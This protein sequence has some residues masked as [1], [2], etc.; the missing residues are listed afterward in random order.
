MKQEKLTFDQQQ[1]MDYANGLLLIRDEKQ[2]NET[3]ESIYNTLIIEPFTEEDVQD[4]IVW[5]VKQQLILLSL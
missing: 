5:K 4:Y 3:I 1:V 2:L